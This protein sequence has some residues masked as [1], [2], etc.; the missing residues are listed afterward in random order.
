M[1]TRRWLTLGPAFAT[2]ALLGAPSASAAGFSAP[3]PGVK[4]L[5]MAGA[6]AAR[7]DDPTA[8]FSNPGALALV[9]KKKLTAGST[10]LYYNEGQFQGL[11]PGF[12]TGTAGEQEQSVVPLPHAFTLAKLGTAF[13]LGIGAYTP[14]QFQTSWADADSFAGR[15]LATSGELQTYD[16][17]TNVAAKIGKTFGVGAGVIYRSAK[18]SYGR[19][20]S[21]FQPGVG[22][23]DIGSFSIETD[24]NG[25]VGWDA[26]FLWQINEKWSF[27]GTY[28]SPIDV[29]FQGAGTLSQ[30]LT[31]NTQFDALNAATQPYDTPLPVTS[32]L[33][34]PDTATVG[35]GLAVTKKV[36]LEVDVTQ[37]GWSR[38]T[39]L[40]VTFPSEPNFSRTLQGAWDDALTYKVGLQ[41]EFA[42]GQILR[43]GYALD[44]TPQGDADV[45][46]F[47]A[48]ADR[49]VVSL[50]YGRDWLDVAVQLIAPS[51]RTTFTNRDGL[52]GT[53]SGNTFLLA[54]SVTK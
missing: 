24:W 27:A 30:I 41:W 16:A 8:G 54:M 25:A 15:F 4:A 33:G 46:A 13:K 43:L 20:L 18:L 32:S 26:G 35:L 36:W 50:G 2:L 31:G 14:Y 51:S 37:T 17:T 19:R 44:E 7:A 1:S 28:R 12:G 40:G 47:F 45:S 48:D 34:F 3:D 9:D 5:G 49:N 6:V 39:G 42:K 11:A 22:P 21:G 29:D 52:N 38:F 10:G 53:Y 23:T